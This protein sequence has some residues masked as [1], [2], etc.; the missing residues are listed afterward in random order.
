MSFFLPSCGKIFHG[1]QRL[2]IL[3]IFLSLL[4]SSVSAEDQVGDAVRKS[5]SAV[6]PG[7]VRIRIVGTANGGDLTVSSQV[8]TG[9]VIS[10]RGEVLTSVLGFSGSSAG[11]LVEDSTGNRST[12]KVVATDHVRKL[13]LL[14]C[15]TEGV[16]PP[17][18]A[19]ERWPAVGAWSV[20]VGKMY[21][22]TQPS[23]SLGIISATRRVHGLAI[24]TDAKISPVNYGGPLVSLSGQVLGI[25]VPLAPGDSGTEINAGV[26][27]YD[28][29]IGF[30]IPAADALATAERLRAGNDLFHGV[31]GVA[32]STR[33]PLSTE[34]V[35]RAVHPGSPADVAGLKKGDQIIT[36]N[37]L[38]MNRF[39]IFES[40]VKKSYAGATLNLTLRR[41]DEI[42][43]KSVVLAD[44]LKRLP[45][46][47]LGI[48]ANRTVSSAD[49]DDDKGV[50]TH[51]LP[52]SPADRAGIDDGAIVAEIDGE[53][54]SSVA[55]L[56]K[57]LS[58]VKENQQVELT[59]TSAESA[60]LSRVSVTA[61][62]RPHELPAL[63]VEFLKQIYGNPAE[64]EWQRAED[65]RAGGGTTV[66]SY[67][68]KGDA[69]I[70]TGVVV[71]L[72]ESTTP[73]EAVL[74][75]WA[76]VAR[77]HRLLLVVPINAEK[78][79]LGRE[80]RAVVTDAIAAVAKKRKLDARRI[81]LVTEEA[82]SQLCT[83]L[84]LNPGL[85]LLRAAV[86]IKSWPR[87]SGLPSAR[88]ARKSPSVLMF[89][90]SI[91]SRQSQALAEQATL[92]LKKSGVW[93]L[94]PSFPTESQTS[95]AE[96]I[97]AWA[98]LL[99]TH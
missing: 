86:Y 93:T 81:L 50:A 21:S 96:Q 78:T 64:V 27:W 8:T 59:L 47:F 41:G 55:E 75:R 99:N 35:V 76:D 3:V 90:N 69:A 51:S 6:A 49:G 48:I 70:T 5:V 68:P 10:E 84:L 24:Q 83:Q 4:S 74:N 33:N 54:M 40:V 57:T 46:G 91:L 14:K 38:Q 17:Q 16:A 80:D 19:A 9:V 23:S 32:F 12:A 30:A 2:P 36:A 60:A 11:I 67:A 13:V 97:A 22:G 31:M 44:K 88:L 39:G 72:S 7:V 89:R 53:K 34:F 85:P 58:A 66:W 45:R 18:F 98:L 79:D 65:K 94:N 1:G 87:V 52:N 26:E 77:L 61:T 29:G 92:D 37:G 20:A 42:L 28:S 71:L 15:E 62:G 25:L 63:P 95:V 82:Q 73:A 43:A 56:R